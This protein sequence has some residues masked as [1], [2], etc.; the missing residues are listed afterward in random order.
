[1]N[2]V[3]RNVVPQHRQTG[4][5]A[6][7]KAAILFSS[8]SNTVRLGVLLRLIER[9]WSVNEI[10]SDLEISQSALSQHLGKLRQAG[11]VR[12]RR[13]RQTVFYHCSDITVIRLLADAGL[14][15]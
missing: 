7:E 8:L 10:A 1:M 2:V 12:S 3:P 14:T 4:T 5:P 11:I 13:D 15:R 9:E 6:L